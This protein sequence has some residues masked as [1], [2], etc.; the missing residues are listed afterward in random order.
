MAVKNPDRLMPGRLAAEMLRQRDAVVSA[1]RRRA[2]LEARVRAYE[3]RYGIKSHAV[4]TAIDRGELTEDQDVC[5][6]LIDY[7]RLRR[8]RDG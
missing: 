4:H 6:W 2:E 3:V 5:D 1:D 7:D 8:T